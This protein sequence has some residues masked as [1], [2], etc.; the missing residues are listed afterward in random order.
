MLRDVGRQKISSRKIIE[1]HAEN[2]FI[3]KGVENTTVKDIVIE[4]GI[5]KGT[6]YLYFKNKNELVDSI[7]ST[8]TDDFLETIFAS[9]NSEPKIK[10]LTRNI[11][12]Y[13][14]RNPFYLVELRRNMA[15]PEV[16]NSTERTIKT[17]MNFVIRYN[18]KLDEYEIHDWHSYTAIILGLIL[19][20]SYRI[21]INENNRADGDVLLGDILKRFF[22][23]TD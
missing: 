2:L 13:F 14:S 12:D 7:I 3:T 1:N 16:Y 22:S 15:C 11:L 6:F 4:A 21:Q 23:C 20:V 8:Y 17:F 18:Q 19:D 5:A 10:I 9:D